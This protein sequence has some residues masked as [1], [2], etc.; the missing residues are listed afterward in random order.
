MTS[1]G[2]FAPIGG[3]LTSTER[4]LAGTKRAYGGS[5]VMVLKSSSI[6]DLRRVGLYDDSFQRTIGGKLLYIS[7]VRMGIAWC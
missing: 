1:N 3:S 2:A 7:W 5:V 4:S 6:T